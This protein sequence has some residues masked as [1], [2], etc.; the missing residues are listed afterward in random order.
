M[1]RSQTK[2]ELQLKIKQLE[3]KIT[4]LQKEK[5]NLIDFIKS[6]KMSTDGIEDITIELTS[7]QWVDLIHNFIIKVSKKCGIL[8]V[9]N[10]LIDWI[11]IK[12]SVYH[13]RILSKFK[14]LHNDSFHINQ[15]P[16]II[17]KLLCIKLFMSAYEDEEFQTLWRLLSKN[18]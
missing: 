5:T 10:N 18:I 6:H 4:E 11:D 14:S 17:S 15:D 2:P 7:N 1:N 9:E 3:N 13:K 8:N 12:P 16:S